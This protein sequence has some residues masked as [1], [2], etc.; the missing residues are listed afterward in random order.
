[1]EGF[2]NAIPV[3]AEPQVILPKTEDTK[4]ALRKV[5]LNS[6]VV[7]P[8][9]FEPKLTGPKPVVLPLHNGVTLIIP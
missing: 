7:T 2:E 6:K 4:K 5:L 9:G 8:S 1:M 3:A